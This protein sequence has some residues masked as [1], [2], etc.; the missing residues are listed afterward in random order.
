MFRFGGTVGKMQAFPGAYNVIPGKVV[1]SLGLRDLDASTE[2]LVHVEPVADETETVAE[3]VHA[4]ALK[5][6]IRTHHEKVW[7]SGDKLEAALHVE[8]DPGLSLEEAHDEARRLGEAIR[9]DNPR[10]SKVSTHIEVAEPEPAELPEV[11]ADHPHLVEEIKRI[12]SEAGE[13]VQAHEV[14]LYQSKKGRIDTVMHC[15]FP[16]QTN[17]SKVHECTE[18]I[19]QALR[20]NLPQLGNVVIH[21]EPQ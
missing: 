19:E 2:S 20:Q 21:A 18:A 1:T 9:N 11:T 14:R 5:M 7:H 10:L 3:A 6:G 4:T 8:V 13:G 12:V 16:S 15:N 17:M